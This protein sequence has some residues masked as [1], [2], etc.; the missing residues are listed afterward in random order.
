MTSI[1]S[2]YD[3]KVLRGCFAM[4]LTKSEMENVGIKPDVA[5]KSLEEVEVISIE[6]KMSRL[7]V[8]TYQSFV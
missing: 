5:T 6:V 7:Q 1:N 4:L 2:E 8:K 3:K